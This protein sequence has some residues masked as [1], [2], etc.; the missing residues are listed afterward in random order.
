MVKLTNYH[1]DHNHDFNCNRD[2]DHNCKII[3]NLSRND[4]LT[5]H[6]TFPPRLPSWP[7]PGVHSPSDHHGDQYHEDEED[8]DTDDEVDGDGG[9][10]DGLIDNDAKLN[11]LFHLPASCVWPT[12]KEF[13]GTLS[14]IEVIDPTSL[15]ILNLEKKKNSTYIYGGGAQIAPIPSAFHILNHNES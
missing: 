4:R 14:G 11:F 7:G 8:V 9:V 15:L 13:D 5:L 2:H 3:K 10:D 6:S 1:H 12:E